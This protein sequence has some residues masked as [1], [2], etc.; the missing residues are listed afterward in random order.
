M[1]DDKNAVRFITL[2]VR[3]REIV[4]GNPI[5]VDHTRPAFGRVNEKGE[6]EL[7]M[8]MSEA[9]DFAN[10]IKQTSREAWRKKN[11]RMDE[12]WGVYSDYMSAREH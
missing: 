5:E 10:D 1:F 12:L 8:S 4:M 6:M 9:S 11:E 7:L 3:V 2:K